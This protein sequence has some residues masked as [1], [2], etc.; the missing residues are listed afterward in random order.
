MLLMALVLLGVLWFLVL[1]FANSSFQSLRLASG[2]LSA[3]RAINAAESGILVTLQ[4]LSQDPKYRPPQSFQRLQNSP[5]MFSVKLLEGRYAPVTLPEG[6]VYLLSTGRERTG[7]ERQV[8]AVVKLG[9]SSESL[10]SFSVFTS[11]LDLNGGSSIL[12]FDSKTGLPSTESATL[13]TNSEK[14]GAIEMGAGTWIQGYIKVGPKGTPGEA[15]PRTPTTK[16]DNTVWKNWSAWSM[17]ES[18]LDQRMDFP[19]VDAP[20]AGKE[21]FKV[22]WKGADIPPGAYGE[23]K[24][25]GGGEVRLQGGTYVFDSIQLT[26][27]SKLSLSG[28][29]PTVI[30][31]KKD[32][33]MSNGTVYNTSRKPR[34]LLFM[35]DK[36]SDA[37]LTGG[38]QAYMV[39]YGPEADVKMT[40]GTNL[41][42]AL[43]AKE[44]KMTGGARLHYDIDL[45]NNPPSALAGGSSS[46]GGI[47][48]V[49]WQRL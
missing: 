13:G 6:S 25:S 15:R 28:D 31:I 35:M 24:A 46:S 1:G 29:K 27:G 4:E 5:E 3:E 14:P 44:L 7:R 34:N 19:P 18:R 48:V 39:V 42:G 41:Y 20:A 40:G 33:D 11:T 22:N 36:G 9:K 38:A 17:E 23:L 16:S 2:A 49:S 12:S 26:G 32:L 43:V 37:K 8:G 21:D 45:K 47:S 30:Y 10:L